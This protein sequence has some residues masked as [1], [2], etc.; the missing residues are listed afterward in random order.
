MDSA[1][2]A[3]FFSFSAW[4]LK[5]PLTPA[6]PMDLSGTKYWLMVE[7]NPSEKYDLVSWDYNGFNPSEKWS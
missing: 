6:K 3:R 1:K 4:A 7:P 2:S 5:T